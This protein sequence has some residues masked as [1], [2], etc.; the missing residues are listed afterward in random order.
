MQISN[1][2]FSDIANLIGTKNNLSGSLFS[3]TSGTNFSDLLSSLGV[4]NNS[5]NS[6]ASMQVT[7]SDEAQALSNQ[8]TTESSDDISSLSAWTPSF[9][10]GRSELTSSE[11]DQWVAGW[12][13]SANEGGVS[14]SYDCTDFINGGPMYYT[15]TRIPVTPASEAVDTQQSNAF[16]SELNSMY[17]TEKAK[18]TSSMDIYIKIGELVLAQPGNFAQ[19]FGFSADA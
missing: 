10:Q 15:G 3:N 17:A 18:G 7:L 1:A 9:L 2:S 14:P 5:L 13:K 6:L 11:M 19:K 16:V 12:V 4:K 8:T